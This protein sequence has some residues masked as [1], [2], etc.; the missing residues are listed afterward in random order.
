MRNPYLK[1]LRDDKRFPLTN[2]AI[3]GRHSE[4]DVA[5]VDE[6]GLSRKH[7]RF[8]VDNASVHISDIGSL[9]G[10][11]VNATLVQERCELHNGDRLVF[12][13]DEFEIVIPAGINRDGGTIGKICAEA[14]TRVAATGAF[15]LDTTTSITVL[16]ADQVEQIKS[17]HKPSQPAATHVEKQSTTSHINADLPDMKDR[18]SAIRSTATSIWQNNHV[19]P[20]A[21]ILV[22]RPPSMWTRIRWL[23]LA[24]FCALLAAVALISH[25]SGIDINSNAIDEPA[26]S[27]GN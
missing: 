20:D 16:N 10:T 24:I 27:I 13:E 14:T 18:N 9:N 19:H 8:S 12:D 5:L 25:N 6:P 7:A 1:R 15:E 4:C 2:R 23:T 17:Q 11:L 26:N 21:P 22:R 3:L